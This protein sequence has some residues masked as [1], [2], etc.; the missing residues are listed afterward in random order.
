MA[1]GPS[2][3]APT[4]TIP[5]L[6]STLSTE[7]SENRPPRA[8]RNSV[9]NRQWINVRA[10]RSSGSSGFEFLISNCV[11]HVGSPRRAGQRS[12]RLRE[13]GPSRIAHKAS[14][15]HSHVAQSHKP[16]MIAIRSGRFSW[17]HRNRVGS[18]EGRFTPAIDDGF[19]GVTAV[20]RRPGRPA[21]A[22]DHKCGSDWFTSSS[23]NSESGPRA[24]PRTLAN[25]ISGVR[26]VDGSRAPLTKRT[27]N[28]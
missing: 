15:E 21:C 2:A 13:R 1:T 26:G 27:R 4:P 11:A 16:V 19:P 3:H 7:Q 8:S 10:N 25:C 5:A 23:K 9:R 20:I 24:G 17:L 22:I 28:S 14:R 6:A 12:T 18:R